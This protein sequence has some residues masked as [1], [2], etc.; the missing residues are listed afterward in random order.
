[1]SNPKNNNDSYVTKQTVLTVGI[2]AFVLGFLSGIVFAL[3]KM[4]PDAEIRTPEMH[5]HAMQQQ[6]IPEEIEAKILKLE[7]WTSEK[8]GDAGA[9]TELGNAYFDTG[10]HEKAIS[11]YTKSLELNPDNA[12]VLTDMGVMYR[13]TGKPAEAVKSFDKAI[14]V[15]PQAEIARFNKGIVLMHDLNDI[16]GAIQ[17]WEELIEINPVAVTPSGQSVE[18]L[19][20]KFK[21]TE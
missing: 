16:E 8:P 5:Q 3:Y 20:Q 6:D 18:Q 19:I 1:M 10:K 11:A 17:A 4:P 14:A 9:W 7:Q 2:I 15:D 13:R 21:K 12:E